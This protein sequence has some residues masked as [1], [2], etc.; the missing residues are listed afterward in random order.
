MDEIKELT[1]KAS[2]LIEEIKKF[3]KNELFENNPDTERIIELLSCLKEEQSSN[4]LLIYYKL[5]FISK[6]FVPI[7]E[8][9]DVI[10]DNDPGALKVII[11]EMN[12]ASVFSDFAQRWHNLLHADKI[13][14]YAN[15]QESVEQF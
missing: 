5:F 7:E 11:E 15:N 8:F 3:L 1:P 6:K 10:Q 2:Q 13:F 4:A 14:E 12:I 9:A